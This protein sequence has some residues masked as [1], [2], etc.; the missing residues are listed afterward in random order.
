[1]RTCYFLVPEEPFY[2]E[3]QE[4]IRKLADRLTSPVFEPHVTTFVAKESSEDDVQAILNAAAL[5]LEPMELKPVRYTGTPLYTKSLFLEFEPDAA[6]SLLSDSLRRA[7]RTPTDYHL[8][9][10]LS[11]AYAKMSPEQQR[12]LARELPLP[13]SPV[14][15][16]RLKA[17]RVPDRIEA[18][19]EVLAWE[20][21]AEVQIPEDLRS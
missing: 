19:E 7:S 4:M 1:M 17:V 10:H 16:N 6:L 8:Q 11:V 20:T 5:D 2:A 12:M 13:L 9:P 21:L 18:P 14:Y 15:F 3:F